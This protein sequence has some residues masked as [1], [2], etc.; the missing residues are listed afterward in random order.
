MSK[1]T[2][3][4]RALFALETT[5]VKSIKTK[6]ILSKKPPKKPKQIKPNQLLKLDI[7]KHYSDQ[8]TSNVSA[9]QNISYQQSGVRKKDIV[10]LK[11]GLF[12]IDITEDLHGKT[13]DM[14]ESSVYSFIQEAIEHQCK[15]GLL[16]HGK[17]YNSNSEKP[18]LKNL[19]NQILN[20]HPS[21][22]AFCSA[23]PKNGG[24]GAVYILFKSK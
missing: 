6:V 7:E 10:R 11:K 20:G 4:D 13:T 12:A 19:V 14:A 21:V 17:G 3:E 24:T 1:L 16:V 15:Y 2:E 9:H 18:I 5:G 23:Q 8:Y 22:L